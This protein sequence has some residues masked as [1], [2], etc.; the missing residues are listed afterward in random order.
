MASAYWMVTGVDKTRTGS[1]DTFY[2]N[3]TSVGGS[4]LYAYLG[5][6]INHPKTRIY[7]AL[8]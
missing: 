1:Y 3:K 8:S 4:T 2:D 7:L 5:K 6:T